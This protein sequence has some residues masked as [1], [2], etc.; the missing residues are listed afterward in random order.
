VQK[1]MCGG[2][3]RSVSTHSPVLRECLL[4]RRSTQ[5]PPRAG[6]KPSQAAASR[7]ERAREREGDN[8]RRRQRQRRAEGKAAGADGPKAIRS[9]PFPPFFSLCLAP[10]PARQPNTSQRSSYRRQR[11]RCTATNSRGTQRIMEALF[12]CYL[13]TNSVPSAVVGWCALSLSLALWFACRC[14]FERPGLPALSPLLCSQQ[15]QQQQQRADKRGK[16]REGK[17][18]GGGTDKGQARAGRGTPRLCESRP[19]EA[20]GGGPSLPILT[21]YPLLPLLSAGTQTGEGAHGSGWLRC[22]ARCL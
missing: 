8:A 12:K 1:A 21:R 7:A 4:Q 9:T 17:E 22:L 20:S 18:R 13:Y 16:N 14:E 5:L 19:T 2:D 3:A 15:Q 11:L 10:S 6:S